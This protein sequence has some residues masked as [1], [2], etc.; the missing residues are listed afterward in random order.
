MKT[1]LLKLVT[2]PDVLHEVYFCDVECGYLA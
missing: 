2:K 1:T